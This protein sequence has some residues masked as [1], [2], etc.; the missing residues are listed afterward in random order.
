V[1]SPKR[2]HE[3]TPPLH[4]GQAVIWVKLQFKRLDESV[5][6]RA[7]SVTFGNRFRSSETSV[8]SQIDGRSDHSIVSFLIS[9]TRD[10]PTA[11][12]LDF[13][14]REYNGVLFSLCTGPCGLR[15]SHE[16][17]RDDLNILY[18]TREQG[19]EMSAQP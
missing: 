10:C 5:A 15:L 14:M 1:N 19:I 2:R 11:I 6:K 16:G 4:A 8:D 12:S 17:H 7:R 9:P 18:S 3:E 13:Q